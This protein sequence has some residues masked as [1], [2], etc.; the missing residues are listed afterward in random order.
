MTKKAILLSCSSTCSSW[1]V[2]VSGD[3]FIPTPRYNWEDGDIYQSNLFTSLSSSKSKANLP[4]KTRHRWKWIRLH[5]EVSDH[6]IVAWI[7]TVIIAAA[8]F[9][10]DIN[11]WINTIHPSSA[12]IEYPPFLSLY[13]HNTLSKYV[14]KFIRNHICTTSP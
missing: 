10:C 13:I 1:I 12:Y 2:Y 4:S 5:F 6:I 3:W 8:L 7:R 11:R 9:S 14:F